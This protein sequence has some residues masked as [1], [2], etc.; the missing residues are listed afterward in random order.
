M[1]IRQGRS[2]FYLCH[3]SYKQSFSH[4]VPSF[5]SLQY[6]KNAACHDT[7]YQK[8]EQTSDIWCSRTLPHINSYTFIQFKQNISFFILDYMESLLSHIHIR[9]HELLQTLTC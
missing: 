2:C 5:L 7:E 3:S 9:L 1:S 6:N 4:Q 8:L